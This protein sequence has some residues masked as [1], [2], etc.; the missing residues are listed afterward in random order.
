L[1]DS[2]RTNPQRSIERSRA[3]SIAS[4]DGGPTA[5][6]PARLHF[7][8]SWNDALPL[9]P[10]ADA[11]DG[12]AALEQ[13]AADR[14]IHGVVAPDVLAEHQDPP[15]RLAQGGGMYP[16]GPLER[17]LALARRIRKGQ[18]DLRGQPR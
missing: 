5:R 10:C 1:N 4:V 17:R 6:R 13:E 2:P 8:T 7:W 12:E 15:V 9:T 11:R 16:A 14:L 18:D 3:S